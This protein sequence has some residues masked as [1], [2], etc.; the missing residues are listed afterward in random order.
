MTKISPLLQSHLEANKNH[1][2]IYRH[3]TQ[4]ANDVKPNE[5]KAK[6]IK[7]NALQGAVSAVKDT[8]QDGKNF[9]KAA[10]TG[11]LNDNNLGRINDLGM[12]AGALLIAT[13]LAS[14]AKTKTDAI[15]QF[16]GGTTFFASMA[17]WPKIFINLPAK[18]MHGFRIDHKYLSAQGDKKDLGLDNQF[19]PMDIFTDE[20][21]LKM[22]EKAG[23][24]PKDEFAKE[25]MQRKL[26]K[27]MLQNRTLWMAT[28]GF[29]TPLMTSLIGDYVTPK[30]RNAVIK[31]DYNKING[32]MND[33]ERFAEYLE[34]AK[35]LH[36]TVLDK[37]TM[38]YVPVAD[39][40]NESTEE[41]ISRHMGT[42]SYAIEH[43]LRRNIRELHVINNFQNC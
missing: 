31:H 4:H 16:I 21:M 40:I 34:K 28:A 17:L 7:E 23:I 32:I 14:H 38:K 30:L 43:T 41:S 22:A 19:Q 8:Y 9:F 25:K 11:K 36:T 35:P 20:E 18:L 15:M 39:K 12:K 1:E 29:A 26:Q 24:D 33:S 3:L 42:V 5:P 37:A 6:L 2:N 10:R 27:T 13:Y